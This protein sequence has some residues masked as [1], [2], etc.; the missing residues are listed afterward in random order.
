MS[1]QTLLLGLL[2]LPLAG[3]GL[4]WFIRPVGVLH[5]L[6]AVTHLAVL[7]LALVLIAGLLA[8]GHPQ[9]FGNWLYLDDLSGVVLLIVAGVG[10]TAAVYSIGYL[11]HELRDGAVAPGEVKRYYTLL[12][13]FSFTMLASAVS[14]NLGVLWTAVAATT[15]ASAPLVDFYGSR[16]PLEAAWKY[17]LL[18][19]AGSMVALLGFLILYQAGVHVLGQSYDFSYPVLGPVAARLPAAATSAAFLLVLV[20]FGTKAGLAPMHTWLPDAH[21][22]APS[23]IC[24][25]LSGVELNCAMLA[26]FRVFSLTAPS[27][28]AAHLR[29]ELLVFGI[30]SVLIAVIFLVTQKDF[31][32]L[33]AYSSIEHMG[34]VTVG[35]G[36]GVPLAV[37]GSLLQMVN[38][39][40]TK[41]LMF[42]ATGN[43]LLRFRTREIGAIGGLA[44][45]MPATAALVLCGAFA[46]AG[47]PPFNLFLSEFSIVGAAA[48]SRQWVPALVVAVLLVIGFIAIVAP[49]NR[50]VFGGGNPGEPVAPAE[51]NPLALVPSYLTL[52]FVLML[53]V[54][55]P[56]P[57]S[58][59]VKGAVRVVLP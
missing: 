49:F 19:T 8:G 24:A 38:H 48:V 44:R 50:M 28:G 57:L 40:L 29:L 10:M 59:L 26:L 18:T 33:L 16:E 56:G 31:K 53:G 11:H 20:G 45:T 41:S 9:A 42:F 39:A 6:V 5:T 15:I 54:W 30:L 22:Q 12:H 32:R 21:S 25:L 27:A 47:A 1:D 51:I 37:F 43:L 14:G 55:I 3:A 23:P 46:I 58:D 35:L 36:V 34:L 2:A 7:A 13:V 17:I 4:S 52:A